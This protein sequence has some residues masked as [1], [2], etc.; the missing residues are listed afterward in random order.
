[1]RSAFDPHD[2]GFGGAPKFPQPMTI[3]F[4]MRMAERGHSDAGD[5]ASLT[6]DAMSSGGMFDQLGGGFCRYSVDKRWVIPHFEKMLY[7]NAQLLRTY[8]RSWLR[9]GK[10]RHREV[11]EMTAAWML[12]EMRDPAG[13]FWSALDA[14][15][16]G[17]EGKYY[18]WSP[19]E[20]REVCGADADVAIERFGFTEAGNFEGKNNPVLAA[21]IDDQAALERARAALLARRSERVRPGTDDKVLAGWTAL[22]A[23]S[24]AES[25]VILNRPEWIRAAGEALVFVLDTMRRDG[26]LMRAYRKGSVNHLGYAEDYAFALE[27]SLGIYEATGEEKWLREA[28]WFADE[29]IRLFS[30]EN[31]GG[32]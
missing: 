23:A 12:T 2:G 32:G 25:G 6:L 9:T 16:E 4:L 20:V 13:G 17:E 26:R 1:M 28:A 7:D 30:D 8:A 24:L 3:D 27:A 10:P 31:N 19:D 11:A 18:V 21:E 15:S 29:A 14:D 22:A 5:M